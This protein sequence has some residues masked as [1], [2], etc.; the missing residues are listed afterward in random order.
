MSLSGE[1]FLLTLIYYF[2][3]SIQKPRQ[4]KV[5]L[6]PEMDL[7]QMSV[8]SVLAASLYDNSIDDAPFEQW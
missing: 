2:M 5:Y 8:E 4:E 3:T 7:I 6:S 1:N